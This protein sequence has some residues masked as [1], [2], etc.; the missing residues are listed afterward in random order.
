MAAA[1]IPDPSDVAVELTGRPHLSHSA[2]RTYL[3]YSLKWY[4]RYVLALPEESI[5]ASL[6]FGSAIHWAIEGHFWALMRGETVPTLDQLM[7]RY[8][9]S[10]RVSAE[11]RVRF[12]RGDDEVTL[13]R[14]AAR[15]LAA[16]RASKLAQPVGRIIGVETE[17]SAAVVPGVPPL[18]ARLDV[19][20]DEG[21]QLV[22]TDLKTSRSRW[23]ERQVRDNMDQLLLYHA[24]AQSLAPGKPIELRFAVLTKTR[25]PEIALHVVPAN[26]HGVERAKGVVGRAW[27]AMQ[28][29]VIFPNPSPQQC[30]SCP[31]R[32]ACDAWS[33]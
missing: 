8:G 21:D 4:F 6:A 17:L 27:E 14:L 28:A 23:S 13:A 19:L 5:S 18:L 22:V 3:G 33:G 1:T 20:V 11:K 9:E 10:W 15:M 25:L 2:V 24:V 32:Q 31:F 16:F 29:G 12:S 26:P 30:P 7:A